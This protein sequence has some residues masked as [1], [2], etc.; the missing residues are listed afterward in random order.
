ME[1]KRKIKKKS[2]LVSVII[3]FIALIIALLLIFL[4]KIKE[5]KELL[6][7]DDEVTIINKYLNNEVSKDEVLKYLSE[8]ITSG[9]RKSVEEKLDNYLKKILEEDILIDIVNDKKISCALTKDVLDNLDYNDELKTFYKEKQEIFK[10]KSLSYLDISDDEDEVYNQLIGKIEIEKYQ[11]NIRWVDSYIEMTDKAYNYLLNNKNSYVMESEITFPKRKDFEEFDTIIQSTENV[12]KFEYI[13]YKII[14]DKEPPIIYASDFSILKGNNNYS[15]NC[16]DEVDDKVE[17]V[18]T[19]DYDINQVG[20]Y[21]LTITAKD[22]EGNE[23]KK[24]VKMTVNESKVNKKPYYIEIIRNQNVVIV[25]GLDGNNEYKNIVKVF[26]CSVGLNNWTPT[27]TFTT[28][29]GYEWGTLNGGLYGQY[30]TRIK[31]SILFHSVPYY[32]MNKNDIE[33]EEFNK[34]GVPA[35]QGCIRMTVEDVKWIY[36]NCSSGITVKIYDG[37]LPLG[38]TKPT[39]PKIDGESPNRG[40]DPTDPDSNNPW[41]NN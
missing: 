40:W 15:F 9:E 8:D 35:S 1:K 27:G 7:L 28:S 11:N 21:D 14:D 19:G 23:S 5:E 6:K 10:T 31:G 16:I 24:V 30:S 2:I 34:L 4:P 26:I 37:E 29:P 17:C 20:S 12:F 18:I 22:K 3:L 32:S 39:A 38:V 25:Y 33:W 36:D 41:K 13:T